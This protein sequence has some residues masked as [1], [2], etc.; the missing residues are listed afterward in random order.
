MWQFPF[1]D[2]PNYSIFSSSLIIRDGIYSNA[3]VAFRL[4][5]FSFEI[6]RINAI[7]PTTAFSLLVHLI[8]QRHSRRPYIAERGLL[9]DWMQP[10]QE[11]SFPGQAARMRILDRS[12]PVMG[13]DVRVMANML[14]YAEFRLQSR[15]VNYADIA[16]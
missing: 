12:R 5:R 10:L 15:S 4:S 7:L 14:R 11:P 16:W 6:Y 8:L 9:P 13:G 2:R 1:R 3:F